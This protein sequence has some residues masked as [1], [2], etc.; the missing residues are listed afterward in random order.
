MNEA[1]LYETLGRKQAQLEAQDAA[2]NQLLGL[3]A[4]VVTGFVTPDRILVNLT[5]RTWTLVPQGQ[6]PGLPAQVNGL[7]VCVVAPPS[8]EKDAPLPEAVAARLNGDV[9]TP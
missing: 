5:D 9:P 4:D 1:K 3:L 7:P 2:Y 8:P 6:R